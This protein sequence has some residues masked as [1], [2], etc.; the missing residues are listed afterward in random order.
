VLRVGI[1]NIADWQLLQKAAKGGL[2]RLEED[3]QR[4]SFE[5][6]RHLSLTGEEVA[7]FRRVFAHLSE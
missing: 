5:T 3:L 4:R 7:E 1:V 6:L 2:V